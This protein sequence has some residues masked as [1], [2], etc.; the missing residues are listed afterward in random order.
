MSGGRW[1]R[2]WRVRDPS[3]ATAPARV[4]GRA[5]PYA[6]ALL[7]GAAAVGLAQIHP[8][9]AEG[10]S[11][12]LGVLAVMAASWR[13]GFPVGLAAAMTVV[14][15][16]VV[17]VLR[18]RGRLEVDDV[19]RLAIFL[20]VTLL[21]SVRDVGRARAEAANA[22]AQA[23]IRAR[24][25]VAD[26]R[27]DLT[28]MVVHDLKNPV[29]GIA[30][31]ARLALVREAGLSAIQ[32]NDLQRIQRATSEL[33]RLIQNLLE[34]G[35]LE[36]GKMPMSPEPVVVGALAAEVAD[37]CRPIA[38]E[39]GK[40]LIVATPAA[41]VEAVDRALTKRVLTNLVVNA[42]RHSG[43]RDI[44]VDV[45]PV[46]ESGEVLVRVIDHGRGIPAEEQARV[47]EKFAS[48][49]RSVK[50][51]ATSDTGLGLPFC[52]LAV[53]HMGGR[54]A[55]TSAPGASTVFAVSLPIHDASRIGGTTHA[56]L[57]A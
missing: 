23:A 34:I 43:S 57:R 42:L 49:H 26:L 19:V 36:E 14:A 37:E 51:D 33:M 45:T 55:L 27:D 39:A 35:K 6:V 4:D 7:S 10:S 28:Q 52:K 50:N 24:D 32:R 54:I 18:S 53:E 3:G 48:T 31:L 46:P 11:L 22:D 13:G 56:A 12:L 47:F 21:V 1:F 2:R 41:G 17:F 9:V 16:D 38:E 8:A 40:R 25:A 20:V 5:T 15:G 44:Q 29:Y 30:I